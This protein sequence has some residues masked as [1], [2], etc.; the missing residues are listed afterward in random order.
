MADIILYV[1]NTSPSVVDTITVAGQP[2]DLTGATIRLRARDPRS[3]TLVLDIVGAQI[4]ILNQTTNKGGVQYDPAPADVT[5]AYEVPPLVGW[6]DVTLPSGK[7]QDTPETFNVFIKAH[8]PGSVDLCTVTDVKR[9][10]EPAMTSTARDGRI[11]ALIPAA[12][13]ALMDE[14]ERELV[15]QTTALTRRF[16][17]HYNGDPQGIIVPLTPY[18]LRAATT[19]TLHPEGT[20]QV[21]AAGTD[22]TLEPVQNQ[23]GSYSRLRLSNFMY[24]SLISTFSQRFGY[25]QLDIQGD[26]GL[27]TTQ[28]VPRSI[29]EACVLTVRTWL[30]QNPAAYAYSEASD[31]GTLTPELPAVYSIPP[32]ALKLIRPWYR[33]Y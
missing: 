25:A 1:G 28:T 31:P 4:T 8:A 12:S 14:L 10:M 27:F 9:A 23:Q 18:D 26:W 11:A 17:V 16:P 20:G 5:T 24:M 2:Q 13:R 15:P 32:G 19:V 30:R 6:W 3:S 21:L 7:V 22:Y 33:R 29:V